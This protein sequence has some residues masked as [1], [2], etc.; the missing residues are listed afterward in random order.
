[1]RVEK[2]V[3]HQFRNIRDLSIQV[4]PQFN[5]VHGRNGQGKTNLLEAVYLAGTLKSFRN[6]KNQE[7]IHFDESEGAVRAVVKKRE[8]TRD[9]LV[10]IKSNG[11]HVSLD[12]KK[13]RNVQETFGQL[14]VVVFSPEDLILSKGSASNRRL[15]LDRA[16]FQFNPGYAGTTKAYEQALKHR[17]AIVKDLRISG[18]NASMLDVFDPQLV[19]LGALMIH[20]RLLFIQS[21]RNHFI[22]AHD[23]ISNGEQK[24]GISYVSSLEISETA[25]LKEIQEVLENKLKDRRQRDLQR[26][27]T[28]VGPQADDLEFTL[29]DRSARLFASQGQHRSLVLSLK[30]AEIQYLGEVLDFQP[31]L[32]LDDV[33]SELDRKRNEQLMNFLLNRSGQ[34]FISTTDPNYLALETEAAHFKIEAGVL[35]EEK[36]I[37]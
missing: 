15:F 9:I 27:Y 21:F 2:L 7:L 22:Q 16:I 17:N 10:Q 28:T 18:K 32:L 29:D 3:L 30:I 24:I 19:E 34:V 23:T 20:Q 6:A 5:I 4:H 31:V 37:P 13:V 1:V 14:H 25:S 35:V 8:L 26:G 12:G 33:S 11:K 36:V